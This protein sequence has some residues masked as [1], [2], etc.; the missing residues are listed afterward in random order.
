VKGMDNTSEYQEYNLLH[1]LEKISNSK[2]VIPLSFFNTK[3]KPF[4]AVTSDKYFDCVISPF[5]TIE[6]LNKKLGCM[7]LSILIPI[8]MEGC[9]VDLYSDIFSLLT[10]QKCITVDINYFCGVV[11][12]PGKLINRFIPKVEPKC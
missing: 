11:C 12:L 10:T 9:P 3:G 6:K 8:D 5:F 1:T 2:A 7:D 4:S